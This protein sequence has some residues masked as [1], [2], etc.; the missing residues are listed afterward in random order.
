MKKTISFLLALCLSG[1][2]SLNA[3]SSCF[4][5]VFNAACAK[6]SLSLATQL[7]LA[8]NADQRSCICTADPA[9][10]AHIIIEAAP[11]IIEPDLLLPDLCC[12][13]APENITNILITLFTSSDDQDLIARVTREVGAQG[14]CLVLADVLTMLTKSGPDKFTTICTVLNNL[15]PYCSFCDVVTAWFHEMLIDPSIAQDG[16]STLLASLLADNYCTQADAI[17]SCLCCSFADKTSIDPAP[18]IADALAKLND[19]YHKT[20]TLSN[21]V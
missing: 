14:C 10:A 3:Y 18:L 2:A 1:M 6:G 12:Y 13:I 9:C 15:E 17:L 5:R 4:C 8:A 20:A 11:S 7:Y 19:L 16:S 21:C